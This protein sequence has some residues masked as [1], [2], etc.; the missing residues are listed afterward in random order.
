MTNGKRCQGNYSPPGTH[1]LIST[2]GQSRKNS[3]DYEIDG[4]VKNERWIRIKLIAIDIIGMMSDD[5]G[6]K[7]RKSWKGSGS[8]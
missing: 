7:A 1:F 5:L 8:R 4:S 2:H 6:T 3:I